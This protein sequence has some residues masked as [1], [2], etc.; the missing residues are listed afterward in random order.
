MLHFMTL[1]PIPL[2]EPI[3]GWNGLHQWLFLTMESLWNRLQ[4]Y[5]NRNI[6]SVYNGHRTSLKFEVS[7]IKWTRYNQWVRKTRKTSSAAARSKTHFDAPTARQPDYGRRTT[8]EAQWVGE[9]EKRDKTYSCGVIT[10]FI[11]KCDY[12]EQCFLGHGYFAI[13]VNSDTNTSV[14]QDRMYFV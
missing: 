8:H 2:P 13:T 1:E 7:V 9:A 14:H 10:V 3:P 12:C 4:K 6:S 11:R 5:W